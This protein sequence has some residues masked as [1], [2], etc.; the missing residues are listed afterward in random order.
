MSCNL[1]EAELILQPF[2]HFTYVTTHSPTLPSLYIRHSSLSNPSVASP[3]SQ[4]ILQPFFRFSY[5]ISSSLNSP[6]EL[7][8]QSWP[9]K[10][11]SYRSTKKRVCLKQKDSDPKG[12]YQLPQPAVLQ[13]ISW[14]PSL[15]FQAALKVPQRN[16]ITLFL[17]MYLC[18]CVRESEWVCLWEWGMLNKREF[19]R[20]R[21][22]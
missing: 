19:V 14:P 10:K 18:A 17:Y 13:T 12:G 9:V 22:F 4:S 2:H 15:H 6:G 5:V 20:L 7:P 11:C 8:M 16:I 21:N 3:P 1:S